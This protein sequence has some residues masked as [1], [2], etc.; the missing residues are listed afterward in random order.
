MLA[1][2]TEIFCNLDDFY[3]YEFNQMNPYL[4]PNPERKRQRSCRL[5]MS[6]IMTII[7]LFHLSHYRT[8]KD[9]YYACVQE[10]LKAYFPHLVSYNRFLELMPGAFLPLLIYL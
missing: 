9:Y 8:F 1:P 7:I 2:V 3:K 6:E 5:S 4:L 10:D